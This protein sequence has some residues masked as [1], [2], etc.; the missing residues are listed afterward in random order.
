MNKSS[1]FM[2]KDFSG[3]L[4][5]YSQRQDLSLNETPDCLN[6]DFDKRGG[7]MLRRGV[8]RVTGSGTAGQY[9]VGDVSFGTDLLWGVRSS[10]G[11]L[12]TWDGAAYTASGVVTDDA[13]QFVRG[14][15]WSSKLYLANCF[16]AGVLTMRT[17]SGVGL[18][19]A[20]TLGNASNDNY[21]APTGGNAPKARLIAD[22]AGFMFWAD[23]VESGTRYRSRVR[24]S[25]FLQPEDFA[26]DD[27]W[28]IDPDDQTDQITA[29]VPFQSRLLVFKRKGVWAVWGNSR[30]NFVVERIAATA[31]VW[32]QEGVD[33]SSGVCY[34]W[35][36]D[37]NVMAYNGQGVVPVG[38][39]I[40]GVVDE[41]DV[42]PGDDHRVCWV[43]DRLFVCF[44]TTTGRRMFVYDPEVGAAGAWTKYDVQATSMWF[45]R[46]ADGSVL[47]YLTLRS[48]AGV[49]SFGERLQ[50][51]DEDAAGVSSRILAYYTTAWFA[52]N[53]SGL[54]KKWRR[55]YTT[56]A[57]EAACTLKVDV[58]HDYDEDTV[59]RMLLMPLVPKDVPNV[60]N[61]GVWGGETWSATQDVIYDFE[62]LPSAGR[63]N[64][65][66]FKF[67]VD[68]NDSR[69]WVD[70][71]TLP[72][73]Q[74]GY[75]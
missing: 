12:W 75:R 55:L 13:T 31:G 53:D 19:T 8:N 16:S 45:W 61:G 22:H 46:R 37:G 63:S 49:F 44:K 43:E 64:A 50:Y 20:A 72:F 68:D 42:L 24:F 29:L 33:A 38:D 18:A 9:I 2:F 10:D 48:S 58:F 59:K 52:A 40:R 5:L 73:V 28:D 56:A 70:S 35:S 32:S 41:G 67:S 17:R 30:D 4:N 62:R 71:F 36:P 21:S 15:G 6:V 1:V 74:K 14:V 69:W 3:G 7:F 66:R 26:A 51:V 23:T 25:H 11:L 34:W 47:M 60:W 57:A 27:F 39:R 65:V 54:K